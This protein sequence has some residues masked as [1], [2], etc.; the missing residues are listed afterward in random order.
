M[1]D[2][3]GGREAII[4]LPSLVGEKEEEEEEGG[5]DWRADGLNLSTGFDDRETRE[6]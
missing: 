1:I 3:E 2:E 6:F 5:G 4:K